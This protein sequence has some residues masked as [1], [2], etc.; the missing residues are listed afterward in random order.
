MDCFY[1][2][3]R[4]IRSSQ[5]V[6]KR[7]RRFLLLG[8]KFNADRRYSLTLGRLGDRAEN[9]SQ[10]NAT[11]DT[12]LEEIRKTES[13][14][15]V[16]QLEARRDAFKN[17]CQHIRTRRNKQIAH[18]D[19][20]VLLDQYAFSRGALATPPVP[21]PTKMEIEAALKALR[22]FM[23]AIDHH[24]ASSET[25]YEEFVSTEGSEDLVW[26]LKQGKRYD[27]LVREETIPWDDLR[28]STY[29]DI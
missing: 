7:D 3:F 27:D 12:L 24:F 6:S 16:A 18:Y 25:A 10:K 19:H 9:R 4:Q 29:W 15:F 22:E 21:A 17:A 28:K 2:A 26:C 11:L 8:D 1:R 13:P 23:N 5:Q 20:R 14:D